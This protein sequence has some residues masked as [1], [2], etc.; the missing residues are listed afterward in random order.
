MKALAP[1]T[2]PNLLEAATPP[3]PPTKQTN[4]IIMQRIGLVLRTVR[5][6]RKFSIAE[7]E[8]LSGVSASTISRI[9]AGTSDPGACTLLA[10]E[11]ALDLKPGW[12]M[13]TAA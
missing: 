10:L 5:K 6:T 13:A 4:E 2:I 3:T 12:V 11:R 1:F 7:V 8:T 9:E